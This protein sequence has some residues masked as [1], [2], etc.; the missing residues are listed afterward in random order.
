MR[1]SLP[2]LLAATLGL[3]VP[4]QAS[5][6][7]P[8][9]KPVAKPSAKPATN[10]GLTL[11]QLVDIYG[12]ESVPAVDEYLTSRKWRF[13]GS[14]PGDSTDVIRY[15]HKSLGGLTDSRMYVFFC[16]AADNGVC[17]KPSFHDQ[18]DRQHIFQVSYEMTKS[19]YDEL[20]KM[21]RIA[22]N[23]TSSKVG[24]NSILTTYRER[25]IRFI[26][27]LVKGDDSINSYLVNFGDVLPSDVAE[28]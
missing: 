20:Q 26:F 13:L 7:K 2:I 22:L 16:N 15:N 3:T 25:N 23:P 28:E 10:T 24:N 14:E 6:Q 12:L 8:V 18:P 11:M 19:V 4:K 5:A 17:V 9:H 21:V 27:K 1:N